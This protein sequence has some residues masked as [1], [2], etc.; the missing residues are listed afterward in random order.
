[1]DSPFSLPRTGESS[2][3]PS[4]GNQNLTES[5]CCR[6]LQRPMCYHARGEDAITLLVCLFLFGDCPSQPPTPYLHGS[7]PPRRGMSAERKCIGVEGRTCGARLPK[8]AR[9]FCRRCR[10]IQV[11]RRQQRYQQNYFQ[12]NKV[13]IIAKRRNRRQEL[14]AQEHAREQAEREKAAAERA[15]RK[16]Y[17]TAFEFELLQDLRRR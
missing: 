2:P 13:E 9:K 4:H 3:L 8:R 12:A 10:K 14:R 16:K 1:M 6:W 17:M 5:R 7:R 11:R 15:E